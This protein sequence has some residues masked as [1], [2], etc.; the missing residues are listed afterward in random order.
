MS[1][2]FHPRRFSAGTHS[3]FWLIVEGVIAFLLG[4][5]VWAQPIG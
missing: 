3:R 2:V 4:L 5:L 1:T